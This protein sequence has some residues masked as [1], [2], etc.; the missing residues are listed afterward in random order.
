MGSMQSDMM[1]LTVLPA[2]CLCL[3]LVSTIDRNPEPCM[4]TAY[5]DG[6]NIFL[7][8]HSVIR[9]QMLALVFLPTEQ[10]DAKAEGAP[11]LLPLEQPPS[12]IHSFS[13]RSYALS[14]LS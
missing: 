11:R 7:Q 12:L 8:R 1:K 2:L 13:S 14:F 10:Q 4:P 5:K 9:C 3:A 6:Y